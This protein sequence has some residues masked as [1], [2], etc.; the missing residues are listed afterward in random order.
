MHNTVCSLAGQAG[1]SLTEVLKLKCARIN[2]I[3]AG[4]RPIMFAFNFKQ[5]H[6]LYEMHM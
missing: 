5:Q 4:L 6:I 3:S 2:A 1:N